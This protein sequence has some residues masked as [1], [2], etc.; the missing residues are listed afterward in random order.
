MSI[1]IYL[2]VLDSLIDQLAHYLDV[3]DGERFTVPSAF[4]S[5]KPE[6]WISFRRE[7]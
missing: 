2:E 4:P 1:V 3:N 5:L 6:S 7:M